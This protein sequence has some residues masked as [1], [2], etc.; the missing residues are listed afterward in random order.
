M[1]ENH[2][3]VVFIM[4][5]WNVLD[6]VG[7]QKSLQRA[8]I[9]ARVYCV[10]VPLFGNEQAWHELALCCREKAFVAS[11]F[12]RFFS[13]LLCGSSQQW[14]DGLFS[15]VAVTDRSHTTPTEQRC[16]R[17]ANDN[18]ALLPSIQCG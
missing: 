14:I 3:L 1:K 13:A 6:L 7:L 11:L 2:A 18:P 15:R 16:F 8:D 12:R 5:H 10:L 4:V 9:G 17:P